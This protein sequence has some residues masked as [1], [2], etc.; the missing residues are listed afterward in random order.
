MAR[1]LN[2]TSDFIVFTLSS[3]LQGLDAGPMTIAVLASV[4]STADGAFVHTRQSGGTNCWWMECSSAQ[5]NYGMGVAARDVGDLTTSEG[6]AV[7]AAHKGNGGAAFPVGRK[8]ILG[9]AT[10]EVTAPSALADGSTPGAGGILQVGKWGTA[11]EF[12]GADIACC[13]VWD[14]ELTS[15]EIDALA[16]SFSSWSTTS[17]APKWL[18]KFTQANA[19]DA[20]SD[21][22]GNGGGSSSIT[23]TTIVSDPAGFF[24][25]AAVDLVVQDATQA[26]T[27][28]GVTLTQVHHLAVADAAQAQTAD[29][30]T[31]TQIHA[32]AVADATQAQSTDGVVLTQVH[33]LTVADATQAQ[34][35]D[36]PTLAQ[37]SVLAVADALQAQLADLVTLTQV[38]HLIVSDARMV[39]HADTVTF[40][41]EHSRPG[42]L[43]VAAGRPAAILT[44]GG[45]TSTLE[46][47]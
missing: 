28:D 22:T 31:L 20:I 12:L 9:G 4:T 17:T 15:T 13:A 11:S 7:Y 46:A 41:G 37:G 2:G 10:T 5:W 33:A 1:R 27:T 45:R 43:L 6:W 24:S 32:L 30:G 25:S 21:E 19:G 16:T 29:A 36:S 3:V 18:V 8:V 26:Q 38:H 34:T 40:A 42:G 39:M 23:G 47:S 44:A 35:A 14:V